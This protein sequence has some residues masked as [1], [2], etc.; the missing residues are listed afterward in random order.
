MLAAT[1]LSFVAVASAAVVQQRAYPSGDV[2]CGS[3]T[4]SVDEVKAAVQN[5]VDH[6]DDPIGDNSYPHAFHN[7][8]GL[9][10]YCSGDSDY[11]EFPI[12]K[13]GDYDGDSPGADRVIFADNGDYCA[14]VT[15]TGASG[16][17]FVSCEG[18]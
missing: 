8:E 5:G 1:L 3:N 7:Y 9:D 17:N 2:T 10:L 14:V 4:Y 15:H 16:N 11:S 6:L 13:S 18:D 12:L